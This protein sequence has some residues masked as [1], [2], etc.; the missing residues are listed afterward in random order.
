MRLALLSVVLHR[1]PNAVDQKPSVFDRIRGERNLVQ[2]RLSQP[3]AQQYLAR[4]TKRRCRFRETTFELGESVHGCILAH[5]NRMRV[6]DA[7]VLICVP[8]ASVCNVTAAA[9]RKFRIVSV[10]P[11]GEAKI[12]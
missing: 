5:A 4:D 2:D 6:T 12:A 10:A 9:D 8:P 11:A 7:F 1:T 3:A